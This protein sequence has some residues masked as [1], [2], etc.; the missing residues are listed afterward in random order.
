LAGHFSACS[1]NV[2]GK[3]KCPFLNFRFSAWLGLQPP[4]HSTPRIGCF[5]T[6]VVGPINSA[7]RFFTM[8]CSLPIALI[9]FPLELVL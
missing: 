7:A 4:L 2:E 8:G 9:L 6:S 1:S 5:N 3:P